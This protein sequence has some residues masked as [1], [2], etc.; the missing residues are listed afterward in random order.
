MGISDRDPN[1]AD[2]AR[3]EFKV[4]ANNVEVGLGTNKEIPP[5][6]ITDSTAKVHEKVIAAD[7]G[8]AARRKSRTA[9]GVSIV[10]K[11]TFAAYTCEQFGAGFLT[12]AGREDR[13]HI[14]EHRA[15][16]LVA[17]IESLFPSGGNFHIETEVVLPNE[18]SA[19]AGVGS[20]FLRRRQ[21]SLRSAGRFRREKRA[22]TNGYVELLGMGETSKQEHRACGLK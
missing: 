6:V 16:T 21:E 3:V 22:I 13:V 19:G 7:V 18:V 15:K 5:K 17:V 10:E 9:V 11:E 1:A 20:T 14:V 4:V 2:V 8:Q 12:Q